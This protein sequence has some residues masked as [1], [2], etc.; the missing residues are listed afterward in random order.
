MLLLL[1]RVLQ[2]LAQRMGRARLLHCRPALQLQGLVRVW[3]E[4]V[5]LLLGSCSWVA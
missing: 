4:L 2:V 1:A 3:V 5:R